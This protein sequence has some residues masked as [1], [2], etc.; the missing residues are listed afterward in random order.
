MQYSRYI[1]LGFAL[2]GLVF[3][4]VLGKTAA[5]V[6]RSIPVNDSAI[7]GIEQFTMSQAIGLLLSVGLMVYLYTREDV[8]VWSGEVAVELSKV[9][10][11]SWDETRRNTLIVI[12]FS[13]VL[14]TVLASLDFFWKWLTDLILLGA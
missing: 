9:T 3:W 8:K 2:A 5:A 4:V 1:N 12:I 13:V 11:P 6:M 7:L 10:W 14:A